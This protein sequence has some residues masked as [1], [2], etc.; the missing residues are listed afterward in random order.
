[1]VAPTSPGANG[2]SPAHR[3]WD[4]DYCGDPVRGAWHE[5]FQM[6]LP[7][8]GYWRGM[9]NVVERAY[10]GAPC[11]TAARMAQIRPGRNQEDVE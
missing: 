5:G 8:S 2:E 11:A 3:V 9:P 1:M 7:A 4:C 6:W 10:C